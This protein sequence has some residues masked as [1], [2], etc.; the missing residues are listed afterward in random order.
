MQRI[1]RAPVLSATLQARLVL[2]HLARSRTSTRRQRFVRDS[3]RLSTTRTRSPSCASL[4]SSCACSVDGRAHDLLVAAVTAGLLDLDGDR[5]VGLVGDD[6]ARRAPAGLPSRAARRRVVPSAR[7]CARPSPAARRRGA[8]AAR[9][10]RRALGVARSSGVRGAAGASCGAGA[11]RLRA[12]LGADAS[13]SSAAAGAVGARRERPRSAALRGLGRPRASLAAS[14]SAGLSLVS[15]WVLRR[16]RGRRCHRCVARRSAPARARAWRCAR[17]RCSP[18]R[19]WRAGSAA[20]RARGAP[21][22]RARRARSSS[23]ARRSVAVVT[24]DRPLAG[25]TWS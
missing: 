15:S 7:A 24:D 12:L 17:R 1:S 2:D 9:G 11:P 4:R 8:P 3:G 6:R 10:L 23:S 5:L 21:R 25:R 22:R 20:R 19:R 16:A 18:A 13:G 14:S